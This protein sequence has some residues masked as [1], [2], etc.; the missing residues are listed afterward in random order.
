MNVARI[1]A[2]LRKHS[3]YRVLINGYADLQA[4]AP[5]NLALSQRRADAVMN[6][7]RR[8]GVNVSNFTTR[9]LGE[10]DQFGSMNT[11]QGRHQNRRVTVIAMPDTTDDS[12]LSQSD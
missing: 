2:T 7:L 5:Y 9:A 6:E 3:R 8:L 10:T 12:N 11:T 4:P 1:A